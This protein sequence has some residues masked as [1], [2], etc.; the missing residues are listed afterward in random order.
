M[1]NQIHELSI[2]LTHR[3]PLNCAYCSSDSNSLINKFINFERIIEIIEEV[4]SK[5]NLKLVSLSGGET[6]L[7]HRFKDL[8][9]YLMK[10]KI[11]V[12]IYTSGVIIDENGNLSS[13]KDDIIDIL[14]KFRKEV[15]VIVNIQ[16]HKQKLVEKINFTPGSFEYIQN[17]I[18]NL[19]SNRIV[20]QANVVPFKWNYNKIERIV[21]HCRE[22]GIKGINFLRYVP[23][24]RGGNLNLYNSR[25]EFEKINHKLIKIIK[26]NNNSIPAIEIRL[27]HPINFLFLLGAN[28]HYKSEENH[29]C[30][31]GFDAPLILPDGK[32]S[33]CPAWKNLS[34]HYAG[35]I[36]SHS[37]SDIWS[38]KKFQI[39]RNFINNNYKNLSFPCN[40]CEFLEQ[41]RG[42]CVAQ[43]ILAYNNNSNFN[44]EK[45][46]LTGPDPQ[47]FKKL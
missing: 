18:R 32:V 17:S 5:F 28:C 46:I 4:Y 44:L 30:R 19:I 26:K 47:C 34:E 33:M 9:D 11:K 37:F 45:I 14:S 21:E 2:E 15:I 22:I 1:T 16:G 23:Q 3:C 42:K 6:F 39:F 29:Y 35:S 25:K 31:G 12:V 43:R 20:V 40:N 41:C 13:I 38:S 8:F 10:K 24:G 27:G 36:Y 7:Y